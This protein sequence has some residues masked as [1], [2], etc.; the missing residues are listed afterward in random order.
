MVIYWFGFIDDLKH[1]CSDLVLVDAFPTF[2]LTQLP[3][4]HVP[5]ELFPPNHQLSHHTDASAAEEAPYQN[6][7]LKSLPAPC[8]DK[9]GQSIF[10]GA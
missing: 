7:L 2:H 3:C 5:P 10:G 6:L 9:P 8:L 4:L 1:S